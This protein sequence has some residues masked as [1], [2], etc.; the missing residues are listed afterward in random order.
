LDSGI[1]RVSIPPDASFASRELQLY[2]VE[3]LLREVGGVAD[4]GT[5]RERLNLQQFSQK[6]KTHHAGDRKASDWVWVGFA[7]AVALGALFAFTQVLGPNRWTVLVVAI[8][9]SLSALGLT[10]LQLKH[11]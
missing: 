7:W 5:T 11:E 4:H 2:L 1:Y 3:T 8:F 10:Y 6:L 9:A